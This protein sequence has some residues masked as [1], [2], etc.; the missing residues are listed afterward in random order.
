MTTAT[1]TVALYFLPD[2][3][4]TL[5]VQKQGFRATTFDVAIPAKDTVPITLT[6][7]RGN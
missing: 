7:I 5:R 2:G 1:R 3:G 4:S 6:L